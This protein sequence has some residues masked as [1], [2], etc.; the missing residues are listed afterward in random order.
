MLDCVDRTRKLDTVRA[1]GTPLDR[2]GHRLPLGSR[3]ES[4]VVSD[5]AQNRHVQSAPTPQLRALILS[6]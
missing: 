5:G 2:T 1:M 6:P 3:P 4:A